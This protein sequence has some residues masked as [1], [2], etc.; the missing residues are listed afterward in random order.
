MEATPERLMQIGTGMW[1]A[2]T[3]VI[4]QLIDDARREN[5]FGLLMSQNMLIETGDGFDYTGADFAGW[6]GEAGFSRCEVLHLAFRH[7]GYERQTVV[8]VLREL[9]Q[10]HPVVRPSFGK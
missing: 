7:A 9:D 2:R 1:A 4:E 5:G 8:A 6:A 10:C 3:I